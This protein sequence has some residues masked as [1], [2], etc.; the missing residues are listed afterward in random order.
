MLTGAPPFDGEVSA[1]VLHQQINAE[2]R[3]PSALRRGISPALDAMVL[4]MLAKA[5][6]ERPASAAEVR[7]DLLALSEPAATAA[8]TRVTAATTPV[9]AASGAMPR[10]RPGLPADYRRRAVLMALLTAVITLIAVA[11]LSGGGPSKRA[12]TAATTHSAPAATKPSAPAATQPKPKPKPPKPKKAAPTGTAGAPPGHGGEPPGHA[13]K[14][15][16]G[17][18]GG[19]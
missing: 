4:A 3:P 1:A 6:D 14:H 10:P 8:T 15:G 12:T 2:P 7:D 18:D 9:T 16:K 13:K 17:G 11:L 5:P 19:D